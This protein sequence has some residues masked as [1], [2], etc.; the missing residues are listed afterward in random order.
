[1]DVAVLESDRVDAA[2]RAD[3]R[4]LWAAALLGWERWQG[5]PYT[6][7]EAGVVPDG[8]HGGLMMFS[9]DPFAV[10]DRTLTVTCEDRPGDAW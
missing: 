2:A 10:V 3:L 8:E 7:T 1:M 5:F 6:Q 9:A 4:R